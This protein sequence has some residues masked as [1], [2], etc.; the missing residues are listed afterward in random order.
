MTDSH[1]LREAYA[2]VRDSIDDQTLRLLLMQLEVRHLI[3][4]Q[5][6][7]IDEPLVG[8]VRALTAKEPSHDH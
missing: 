8:R 5:Q 6:A 2:L 3:A 1:D 7:S 4:D